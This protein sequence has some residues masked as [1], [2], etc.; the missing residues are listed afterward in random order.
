MPPTLFPRRPAESPQSASVLTEYQGESVVIRVCPPVD[1]DACREL[2]AQLAAAEAGNAKSI[3]LDLDGV[4]GL[5][6]RM[7][8]EIL[9]ASRRSAHNGGRLR[10]TRGNGHVSEIFR[11]TGLDQT[12]NFND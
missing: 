11:L 1:V 5:D 12:I 4:D 9:R 7:L 6:A 10:V 3:L 8:H 2:G